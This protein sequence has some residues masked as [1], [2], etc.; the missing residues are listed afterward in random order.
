MWISKRKWKKIVESTTAIEK[1]FQEQS[2]ILEIL[3][4]FCA[5][6]ANEKGLGLLSY[7]QLNSPTAEG[8]ENVRVLVQKLLKTRKHSCN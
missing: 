4:E 1:Q 5:S 7:Q 3:T 2:L 6:V 8:A